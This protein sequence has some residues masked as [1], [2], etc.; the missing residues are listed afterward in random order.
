MFVSEKQTKNKGLYEKY[1]I[2][3]IRS[4]WRE[5]RSCNQGGQSHE[6]YLCEIRHKKNGAHWKGENWGEISCLKDKKQEAI[7][8]IIWKLYTHLYALRDTQSHW[9]AHTRVSFPVRKL[10]HKKTEKIDERLRNQPL[11]RGNLIY[12]TQM[13]SS[14]MIQMT[15]PP[16]Y[17]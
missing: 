1:I 7:F 14:W 2:V 6:T 17:I 4:R 10:A 9:S 11:R 15:R 5:T 16:F 8:V 13:N 12:I 3:S